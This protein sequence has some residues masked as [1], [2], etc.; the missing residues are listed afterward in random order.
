MPLCPETL[1]QLRQAALSKMRGQEKDNNNTMFSP[2]TVSNRTN[3]LMVKWIQQAYDNTNADKDAGYLND[4]QDSSS[5][6]YASLEGAQNVEAKGHAATN[7]NVG[8]LNKLFSASL[9]SL[10]STDSRNVSYNEFRL[11]G[12][13]TDWRA[14][15]SSW[16]GNGSDLIG[17][18]TDFTGNGTMSESSLDERSWILSEI[19][20]IKAVVLV[21]VVI[22]L[23]LSTCKVVFQTF[24]KFSG[25]GGKKYEQ[26]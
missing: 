24:S 6:G 20:L 8:F 4:G 25:G 3:E 1:R 2:E 22:L 5:V 26:R 21:V 10:N 12:Y 23:L 7:K 9:S 15:G 16:P 19:H 14:N 11:G 18:G 13:E 17:N